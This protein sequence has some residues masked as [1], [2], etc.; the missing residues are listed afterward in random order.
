MQDDQDREQN[1]IVGWIVGAA[2]FIAVSISM[3]FGLS[4]AFQAQGSKQAEAV[5]GSGVSATATV[6]SASSAVASPVASGSPVTATAPA[7]VGNIDTVSLFFDVNKIEPPADSTSKLDGLVTYARSNPNS[8]I[9]ISGYAD[10]TGDP[11]KNAV[12]AKERAL[13]VKNQLI[14]AG[15]PEDRIVMQKPQDITS[16]Q[17]DDRQARRVDV[18]IV[19]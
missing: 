18:F 14:S 12:L 4:A 2:A 15:T 19:Q 11:E 10:K 7:V 13:A 9:A 6:G 16:G 5:S 8:K 3:W 17:T 1:I